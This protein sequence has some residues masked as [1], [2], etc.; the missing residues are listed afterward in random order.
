MNIVIEEIVLNPLIQIE[1]VTDDVTISV[2]E[3]VEQYS[4]SIEEI[5]LKGDKGDTG[6]QGLK[7]IQ[8]IQ[9]EIGLTGSQ[10]IQGEI[11]LT[12]LQGIQ[13]TQGIKGDVGLQGIQ[14]EKG[15]VGGSGAIIYKNT[16]SGIRTLTGILP[17]NNFYTTDKGQEG[18][19][20]YDEADTTS[21]D[22]TGTILVT[23]DGKRVKRV[24]SGHVSVKWFGAEGDG[25]IDD[26]AT[27]QKA[28]TFSC[29]NKYRLYIPTGNYLINSSFISVTGAVHIFGDGCAS[30]T[31]RG[32]SRFIT[33]NTTGDLFNFTNSGGKVTLERISFENIS[34]TTPVSGS[35]ALNF[36]NADCT[37]FNQVSIINFY[38]NI[39]IKSGIYYNFNGLY[40]F[41]PVNIGVLIRNV[42]HTDVGDMSF[43]GCY[44]IINYFTNRVPLGSAI[45]WESGGGLRVTNSKINF[46]GNAKW[47]I[48][49]DINPNTLSVTSVFIINGNSIENCTD[50]GI[51]FHNDNLA[52][53]IGKVIIS[54]NE[55]MVGTFAVKIFGTNASGIA[56]STKFKGFVISG[57]KIDGQYGV[58]CD[59]ANSVNVFG[60]E[61]NVSQGTVLFGVSC[62]YC[63][64]NGNIL[65]PLAFGI[66]VYQNGQT[67]NTVS[68]ATDNLKFDRSIPNGATTST[69][70]KLFEILL[71]QNYRNCKITVDVDAMAEGIGATY[72]TQTRIFSSNG[73]TSTIQTVGTDLATTANLVDI[74]YTIVG[75]TL[76]LRV[77]LNSSATSA[78]SLHGKVTV[79][80]D[81][82]VYSVKQY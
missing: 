22:N 40:C 58:V 24:L 27:I 55:F 29:N 19:W 17:N 77:K 54:N 53:S 3:I 14:G 70:V 13:G 69:T 72:L 16:I 44:F 48:G 46:S 62:Y 45:K 15:E 5:G 43:D 66:V 61:F 31:Q 7:G 9:G 21:A 82:R 50:N 41:D 63:A 30:S 36:Q 81:G 73:G 38:N 67:D 34:Y 33:T 47:K 37:E 78:T 23:A 42:T 49:I 4:I 1:E 26:T 76:A 2:Q 80:I 20:Y 8:G 74:S 52:T 28:V 39:F 57:N 64:Q 65:N 12:G 35:V 51:Y 18:N 75:K 6:S 11:G 79:K 71:L 59:G 68:Y 10:G 32:L 56:D 60:N 25:V